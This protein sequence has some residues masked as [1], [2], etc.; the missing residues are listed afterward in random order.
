MFCKFYFLGQIFSPNR[1]VLY[2]IGAA[3]HEA[4][5]IMKKLF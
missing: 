2:N 5:K 4:E 3:K 1:A